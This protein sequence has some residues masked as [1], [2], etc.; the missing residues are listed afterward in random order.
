MDKKP[1]KM[2]VHDP[3]VQLKWLQGLTKH[4][5]CKVQAIAKPNSC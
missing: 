3:I 4:Y 1:E 5:Q 2:T